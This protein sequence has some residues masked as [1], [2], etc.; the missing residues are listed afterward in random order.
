M[1]LM[2]FGGLVSIIGGITF[3][4]LV[5]RSMKGGAESAGA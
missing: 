4:V 5:Y 3:L 1:G 2:G